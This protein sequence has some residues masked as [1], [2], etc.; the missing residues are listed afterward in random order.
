ML[1]GGA[2]RS[3]YRS[4][5]SRSRRARS[6][7]CPRRPSGRP[8]ACARLRGRRWALVPPL[9]V[10]AFV[11]IARA[12]ERASAQGLTYLAL[13]AVPC[14]PRSRSA[15][16]CGARGPRGRCSCRAL[17]ALAWADRGGL[18]GEARGARALG[19]Q[20]RRAR[21]AA[22][23]RHAAALARR[24]DRRDGARRH[25]ARRLRPAAASEQRAQRRAPRGRICRG[26]R[27]RCSARR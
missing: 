15:G 27:A 8:R 25:R 19:A 23:R 4:R 16:C 9:S 20:L 2:R 5:C 17:F 26:C 21:R 24:R 10:I 11:L 7:R 6:W 18:A 3:G 13:C 14:S 22:R 1:K 12:A